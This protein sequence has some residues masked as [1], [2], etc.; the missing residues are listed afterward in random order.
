MI[1]SMDADTRKAQA[2][3]SFRLL[4]PCS[5]FFPAPVLAES[6]ANAEKRCVHNGEARE[7]TPFDSPMS[8]GTLAAGNS[9]LNSHIYCLVVCVRKWADNWTLPRLFAKPFA[10]QTDATGASFS[11]WFLNR[12]GAQTPQPFPFPVAPG[13]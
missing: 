12:W 8:H 6:S 4:R 1:L 10:Q 3:F 2:G 5:T 13:N 7:S 9:N 11:C